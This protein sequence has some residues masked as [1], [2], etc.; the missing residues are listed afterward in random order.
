MTLKCGLEVTQEI[1]THPHNHK[2]TLWKQYHLRLAMAA[3]VVKLDELYKMQYV[4]RSADSKSCKLSSSSCCCSCCIWSRVSSTMAQYSGVLWFSAAFS[5]IGFYARQLTSR[6]ACLCSS[7]HGQPR[8]CG[9]WYTSTSPH[10]HV[11]IYMY[12]SIWHR[13]THLLVELF[14]IQIISEM[15]FEASG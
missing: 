3:Q 6:R 9:W 4:G 8:H 5:I 14:A 7:V 15:T 11:C 13:G 2:Q 1:D 12:L 10:S